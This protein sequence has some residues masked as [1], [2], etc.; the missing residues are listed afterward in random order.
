MCHHTMR[1]VL[2]FVS[3]NI[4]ERNT[5]NIYKNAIAN[6]K[7]PKEYSDVIVIQID[8]HLKMLL[9]NTKRSRFYETRCRTARFG[10]V[11]YP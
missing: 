6:H 8:Q 7:F 2:H 1:C 5:K 11:V 3:A 4:I 9:K 10:K